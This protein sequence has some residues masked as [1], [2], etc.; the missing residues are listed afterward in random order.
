MNKY[1]KSSERKLLTCHPALRYIFREVLKD[2]DHTVSFGHRTRIVQQELYFQGR[3]LIDG[4]W[5]I[6]NPAL[7]VTNCDGYINPSYHNNDGE[8]GE[9]LSLAI[10]VYPYFNGK[11]Q[12][13]ERN[14]AFFAGKV[15]EIAKKQGIPIVWG[16]DWDGD[17]DVTDNRLMD[18]AHYQLKGAL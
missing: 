6:V 1:S 12:T 10:D 18:M 4:I 16:G 13:D 8:S 5:Q 7:R 17:Y 2:S 14:M 3:E 15:W 11:M 9:P